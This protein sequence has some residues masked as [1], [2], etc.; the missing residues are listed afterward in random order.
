MRRQPGPAFQWV[1]LVAS[2]S[3]STPSCFCP[4]NTRPPPLPLIYAICHRPSAICQALR[5][6]RH[7]DN[8][9]LGHLTTHGC[10]IAS[11]QW[12][13]LSGLPGPGGVE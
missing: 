6:R 2:R 1:A 8:L 12:T 13:P 5:C 3:L 11:S 4:A 9:G 10:Q 7:I